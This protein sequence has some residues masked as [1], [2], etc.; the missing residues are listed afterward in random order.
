MFAIAFPLRDGRTQWGVRSDN[1]IR[2][3]ATYEE[4]EEVRQRCLEFQT[5]KC[6]HEVRELKLH[7]GDCPMTNSD[8]EARTSCVCEHWDV[9]RD[10]LE[11]GGGVTVV[12]R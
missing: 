7:V 2:G 8:Q 5:G 12:C 4:A 9:E 11:S 10:H 3:F 1:T 6:R